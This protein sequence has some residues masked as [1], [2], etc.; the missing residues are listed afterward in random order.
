LV[1]RR[2]WIAVVI[3]LVSGGVATW[4]AIS[5]RHP[6]NPDAGNRVE[7]S[8]PDG[9]I[10]AGE[11]TEADDR[12]DPADLNFNPGWIGAACT[13]DGDCDYDKGFCLMPEEGF[14][15]GYCSA[16]CRKLCPDRKGD[17]YSTTFCVEDPTFG[18]K[19]ICLAQCNL[20]LTTSG[21]RPGYVCTSLQRFGGD[22][23]RMV[24]LPQRGSPPPPTECT[25]KLQALGLAFARPD[26][27]DA[28]SRPAKPGDPPPD[29][30]ICQIDTPVLLASPVHG[31]DFRRKGKRHADNLLVAC[32]FALAID[33]FAALLNELE[34]VEVTHVGTYVCRGVAGTHSLSGHGHALAI[35]VIGFERARYAPVTIVDHY[36]GKDRQKRV[37]L[38]NLV[39]KIREAKIFD[40]ILTPT[41]NRAHQ[42]HLHLETRPGK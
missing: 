13:S 39:K 10:P 17:L 8:L 5:D 4:I 31:V 1:S 36:M 37:F 11:N 42:D 28:P 32:R 19:G 3:V 24:C 12:P 26:L 18:N 40:V 16:R 6:E 41:S 29:K 9:G 23:L 38:R 2:A 25:R 22:V 20:H 7:P 35:D 21:C 30:E 14:P 15:R 27:A 34:V 33:K